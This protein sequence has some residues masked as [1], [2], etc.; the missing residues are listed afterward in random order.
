MGNRVGVADRL[1]PKLGA[2]GEALACTLLEEKGYKIIERNFKTPIGEI[3]IVA[4]EGQT[5][6]FVEV[7][8]RESTAFGSAKWAV[9]RK[10]AAETVAGSFVL[11]ESEGLEGSTGQV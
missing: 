1:L 11:L 3:D 8:T 9:D 4:R 2:R 6:V 10:E 5:L 7:K